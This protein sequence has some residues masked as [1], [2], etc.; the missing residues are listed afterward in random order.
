MIRTKSESNKRQPSEREGMGSQER[1]LRGVAF[2]LRSRR[3]GGNNLS[4]VQPR[5][6]WAQEA[7][8]LRARQERPVMLEELKDAQC[9]QRVLEQ[10]TEWSGMRLERWPRAR[11]LWAGCWASFRGRYTHGSFKT[12]RDRLFYVNPNDHKVI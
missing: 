11:L 1:C 9:G 3:R 10:E 4:A 6:S 7:A 2:K 8:V 12:E 5:V